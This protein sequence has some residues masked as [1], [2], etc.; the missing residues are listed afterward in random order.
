MIGNCECEHCEKYSD[1]VEEIKTYNDEIHGLRD[2]KLEI[3][4][5]LNASIKNVL[6]LESQLVFMSNR[7]NNNERKEVKE[8]K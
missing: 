3:E 8:R 4:E 2:K 6:Y 7:C 1:I 5:K